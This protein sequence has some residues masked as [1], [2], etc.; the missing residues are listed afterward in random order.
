M[1]EELKKDL[2]EGMRKFV[3]EEPNRARRGM[4][5]EIRRILREYNILDAVI[6]IAQAGGCDISA[7][8][9]FGGKRFEC[10]LLAKPVEFSELQPESKT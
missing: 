1:T 10:K 7:Y 9:S 2:E 4:R 3:F 5:V 6:T 8:I